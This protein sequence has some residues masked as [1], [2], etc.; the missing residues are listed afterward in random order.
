MVGV[1]VGKTA[2]RFLFHDITRLDCVDIEPGLFDIVRTNFDSSWMNDSRVRLITEDGRNYINNTN[3]T[4]DIISIEVGQTFR[5][6]ISSFYTLDFY[7]NVRERLNRNGI[8]SQFIPISFFGTAEFKSLIRTFLEVFPD[9]ILWYNSAELLLIGN[10]SGRPTLS[11]ERLN[12][13]RV[14]GP[15]RKDLF[16]TYFGGPGFYLNRREV[17]LAG[18]L[19]GP[20][21]LAKLTAQ[22]QIYR[23]DVPLLEYQAAKNVITKPETIVNQIAQHLDPSSHILRESPD[24]ATLARIEEI[25][26]L[27]LNDLFAMYLVHLWTERVERDNVPLLRKAL[28][29]NPYNVTIR[30]LLANALRQQGQ[31]VEAQ[32]NLDESMRIDPD[33]KVSKALGRAF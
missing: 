16:Y 21:S 30:L 25:R 22:A 4:Y 14:D 11:S 15:V 3:A 19:C 9:S 31:L 6:G 20:D 12:S 26:A 13:L 5:P 2:S 32:K 24:S 33:W 7:R 28:E 18:F 23:D 10:V 29:L 17:F 27:N 1:G 8:V